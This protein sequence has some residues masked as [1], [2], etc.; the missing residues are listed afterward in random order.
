MSNQDVVF[1]DIF[2][3][4]ERVEVLGKLP[5]V[6]WEYV[7]EGNKLTDH[8][9]QSRPEYRQSLE[10]LERLLAVLLSAADYLGND[11]LKNRMTGHSQMLASL[12]D[13]SVPA[14]EFIEKFKAELEGL[15]KMAGP[16]PDSVGDGS[17]AKKIA[18]Q[19]LERFERVRAGRSSDLVVSVETLD[20]IRNYLA[21]EV[22]TEGISSILVVDNAGTLVVNMGEKLQ[23]DVVALA[24]VAAANFAATEKI[25]RLIGESDFVL[26]FYKGHSESFH[27]TRVGTEYIIVTIFNNSLSL[28][29]LRLK[30][31]EVA[32]VLETKLPK[33]EV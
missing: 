7:L 12:K 6:M 33:R 24:A 30:I 2:E 9:K 16:R 8:L 10:M 4:A 14:P 31:N 19:E 17:L 32:Q 22:M 27:F 25:A 1:Q 20:E 3:G 18:G 13:N 26:L 29:L 5:S 28:G 21:T 23:M 11:A 15:Q